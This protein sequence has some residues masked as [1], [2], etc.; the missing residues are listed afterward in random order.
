[1]KYEITYTGE[2]DVYQDM[3]KYKRTTYWWGFSG[4]VFFSPVVFVGVVL[5]LTYF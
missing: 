1:M 3:G 2:S 4:C 5:F